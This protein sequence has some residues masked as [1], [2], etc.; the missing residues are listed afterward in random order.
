[1]WDVDTGT[2]R[3]ALEGDTYRN[4]DNSIGE[5]EVFTSVSFSPD[6]STLVSGSYFDG[7]AGWYCCGLVTLWEADTGARKT[8]LYH[9]LYVSSVSFSPDGSILAIDGQELGDDCGKFCP[10]SVQLRDVATGTLLGK[11]EGTVFSPD[12]TL[13]AGRNYIDEQFVVGLWDVATGALRMTL[14]GHTD[15]ILAIS[16]SPGGQT[17]ASAGADSTVRLWNLRSEASRQ[18]LESSGWGPVRSISVSPDGRTLASASDK[19]VRL[20]DLTTGTLWTTLEGHADEVHSVSFSPDGKT[21]ASADEEEVQVWDLGGTVPFEGTRWDG[22]GAVSFSPDGKTLVSASDE[23]VLLWE[24]ATGTLRTTLDHETQTPEGYRDEMSIAFSPDG[25]IL[26]TARCCGTIRL[27]DAVTGT[28]RAPL[29]AHSSGIPSVT[30]SQDGRTLASSSYDGTVGLWT[31][32]RERSSAISGMETPRPPLCRS[33]RTAQP[34]PAAP[35]IGRCGCGM[36]R[37]ELLAPLSRDIQDGSMRFPF[38]RMGTSLPA[39]V[40]TAWSSCGICRNPWY[41]RQSRPLV[42]MSWR[43]RRRRCCCQTIP[44]RSTHSASMPPPPGPGRGDRSVTPGLSTLADDLRGGIWHD[45]TRADPP[46]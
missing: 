41:P 2:L 13:L 40:P 4:P 5:R 8:S 10:W 17:L 25:R 14:E 9:W 44:T 1:M 23:T 16:F 28:L 36:S 42:Q 20:W 37:Q 6:G 39:A 32:R 22:H 18:V 29:I 24:V 45:P 35:L 43:R 3:F 7:G 12:G 46:G 33:H 21:L 31:W 26:A 27:W 34:S 19:T 11:A 30:F 38:C 15:W